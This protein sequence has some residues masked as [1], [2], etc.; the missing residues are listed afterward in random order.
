MNGLSIN[1]YDDNNNS[2]ES[3]T[4]PIAG[5]ELS[6]DVAA[7]RNDEGGSNGE[8]FGVFRGSA[9]VRRRIFGVSPG[10]LAALARRVRI[11]SKENFLHRQL[12]RQPGQFSRKL[13]SSEESTTEC[14]VCGEGWGFHRAWCRYLELSSGSEEQGEYESDSDG[15]APDGWQNYGRTQP[16]RSGV[17]FDESEEVERVY[18]TGECL[19]EWTDEDLDATQCA[20]LEHLACACALS[21]LAE[22]EPGVPPE[23]KAATA[24]SLVSSWDGENDP[25]RSSS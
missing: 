10:R 25:S 13:P 14:E 16:T 12:F 11:E 5:E 3:E 4:F 15:E 18:H 19:E 20:S 1:N 6:C 24:D 9:G 7:V 8:S 23:F 17:C 21:C 2:D 22:P